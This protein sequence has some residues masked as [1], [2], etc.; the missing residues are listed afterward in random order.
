MKVFASYKLT[1]TL[2]TSLGMILNQGEPCQRI[3]PSIPIYLTQNE[4]FILADRVEDYSEEQIY[5]FFSTCV[6]ECR[7]PESKSCVIVCHLPESKTVTE[8]L[9]KSRHI[10]SNVYA[11]CNFG[12][13]R[14]FMKRCIVARNRLDLEQA[15]AVVISAIRN[16]AA[17][18]DRAKIVEALIKELDPK[19]LTRSCMW[20]SKEQRAIGITSDGEKFHRF[21]EWIEGI[22]KEPK[23]LSED[24]EPE[25]LLSARDW[26]SLLPVLMRIRRCSPR[27]RCLFIPQWVFEAAAVMPPPAFAIWN[28]RGCVKPGHEP[29]ASTSSS[30]NNIILSRR[31]FR[32]LQ[33]RLLRY[34][35][36]WKPEVRLSQAI[37]DLETDVMYRA[38]YIKLR[39]LP[40]ENT[41]LVA[42]YFF[43][44][45]RN[46]QRTV[47]SNFNSVF[48]EKGESGNISQNNPDITTTF[49]QRLNEVCGEDGAFPP[50]TETILEQIDQC[51]LL[52]E[53]Y[54]AVYGNGDRNTLR[55]SRER[56][57]GSGRGAVDQYNLLCDI[58]KRLRQEANLK[59]LPYP[60]PVRKFLAKDIM[61]FN[62]SFQDDA[63]ADNQAPG[64]DLWLN[65]RR[66]LGALGGMADLDISDDVVMRD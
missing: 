12:A 24:P 3:Y 18:A 65:G 25:D 35:R 66:E 5:E 30:P 43:A 14:A 62:N 34:W 42:K 48:L 33:R 9:S 4:P 47:V 1:H 46:L 29:E 2:Q 54:V 15:A 53:E 60:G 40:S 41:L 50:V 39:V 31:R 52:M 36:F 45:Q 17:V 11:C 37:H 8:A 49:E 44:L 7:L 13:D 64:W 27:F 6:L 21:V 16:D 28:S 20:L 59:G 63:F 32:T 26:R 22:F 10:R 61:A 38:Q 57:G 55:F 51:C 19:L 58:L 56:W 23:Y